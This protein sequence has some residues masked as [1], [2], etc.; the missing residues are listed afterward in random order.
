MKRYEYKTITLKI[1]GLGL[2]K[3]KEVPELEDTLNKDGAE[4][5][6]LSKVVLPTR[7]FGESDSVIIIFEREII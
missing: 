6:K 5:W 7:D 2:F 3:R 1:K 4:G